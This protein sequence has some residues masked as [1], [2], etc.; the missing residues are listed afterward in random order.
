[1]SHGL[2]DRL[3]FVAR[4]VA[5]IVAV[6]GASALAVI[7]SIAATPRAPG[8][9]VP[10][11]DPKMNDPRVVLITGANR[12]LGLEFAKEYCDAG[13]TVLA[14]AREPDKA[15]EL[16]KLGERVHVVPL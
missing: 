14:T 11:E 2:P 5:S 6:L 4:T 12:G 8:G 7:A 13:W 15:E 3:R 9:E 10:R 1:M 16:L